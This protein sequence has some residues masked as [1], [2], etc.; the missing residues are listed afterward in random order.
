MSSCFSIPLKKM[1]KEGYQ[2]ALFGGLLITT[3]Q[4]KKSLVFPPNPYHVQD[5]DT[6]LFLQMFN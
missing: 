5:Q 4:M 3:P 2:Q 6:T 1:C